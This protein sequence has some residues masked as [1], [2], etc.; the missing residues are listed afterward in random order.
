MEPCQAA[1]E[2]TAPLKLHVELFRKKSQNLK[3][4]KYTWSKHLQSWR[5]ASYRMAAP[6]AVKVSQLCKYNV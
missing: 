1:N 2:K 3:G 5:N 4:T 6:M